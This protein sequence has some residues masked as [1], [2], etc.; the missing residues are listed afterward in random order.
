M[1]CFSS[2]TSLEK[3]IFSF[4]WLSIVYNFWVRGWGLGRSLLSPLGSHLAQTCVGHK[5]VTQWL[6][7][8]HQPCCDDK[9]YIFWLSSSYLAVTLYLPP[10]PQHF[11]SPE[12][13]DLIERSILV[14]RV[15]RSPTLC[16]SLCCFC[17]CKW[18]HLWWWFSK[19]WICK[20]SRMLSEVI[21]LLYSF[22]R[23]VDLGSLLGS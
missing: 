5:D 18:K 17:L 12:C 8:V 4:K 9:A 10:L 1:V 13:R 11:L 14:L 20:Y 6:W 2:T 7:C 15:P 21:W 22:S 23:T 16:G 3:L 19:G